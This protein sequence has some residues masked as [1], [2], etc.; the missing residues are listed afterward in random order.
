[1]KSDDEN[2]SEFTEYFG[3]SSTIIDKPGIYTSLFKQDDCDIHV[4]LST[5]YEELYLVHSGVNQIHLPPFVDIKHESNIEK[6]DYKL[7]RN[8][9]LILNLMKPT[10]TTLTF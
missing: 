7:T 4:L 2:V 5:N 3:D 10:N 9:T 1:M 6:N 8:F